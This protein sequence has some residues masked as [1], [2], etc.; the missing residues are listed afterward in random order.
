MAN[1]ISAAKRARQ[2]EKRR[3]RHRA[4]RT[5]TRTAVRSVRIAAEEGNEE[6]Y[7]T[8]LS[9]AYSALDRAAKTGAIPTG[10]ADRTKRRLAALGCKLGP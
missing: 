8:N 6:Q 4:R 1:S 9:A 10:A 5:L 2:N 7:K 3:D